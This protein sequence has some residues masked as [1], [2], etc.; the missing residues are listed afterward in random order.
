VPSTLKL[1]QAYVDRALQEPDLWSKI[2]NGY[3]LQE[4]SVDCYGIDDQR[5][6]VIHSEQARA[7]SEKTLK[8]EIAKEIRSP[9]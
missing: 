8:K 4:F 5:W 3:K 2:D 9:K 7:R 1:E 6:I